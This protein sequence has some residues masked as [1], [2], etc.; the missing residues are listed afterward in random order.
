MLEGGGGGDD[1]EIDAW[2]SVADVATAH[3]LSLLPPLSCRAVALAG[4]G[5]AV[6]QSQPVETDPSPT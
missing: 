2:P 4:G 5:G 1:L 6:D 3:Y